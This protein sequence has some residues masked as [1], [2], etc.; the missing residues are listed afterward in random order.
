MYVTVVW[1]EERSHGAQALVLNSKISH[2]TKYA[3]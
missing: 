3:V 1:V 2:F